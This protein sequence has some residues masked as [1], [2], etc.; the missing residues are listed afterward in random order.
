MITEDGGLTLNFEDDIIDAATITHQGEI[1]GRGPP[2]MNLVTEITIPV[3]AVFVGFEVISKV[4]TTL[5]AAD[6]ADQR[7]PRDRPAGRPD[8]G[9]LPDDF[10]GQ[11]IGFIAIVFGTINIVGGFMVTDRMLEM[12]GPKKKKPEPRLNRQLPI[13]RRTRRRP[14]RESASRCAGAGFVAGRD[15]HRQLLAVHH[16]DQAGHPP[17]TARRG[18]MIAAVGMAIAVI[19]TLCLKGIGNWGII[20]AGI[21][22]A[23]SS[24]RSPRSGSR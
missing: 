8:R 19:T 22:S 16:R 1:R 24:A 23:R 12:F 2:L 5:H 17:T 6:V 3:L 18:N 11:L 13:L 9:R 21:W 7:D 4:P 10:L 20:I 15:S 14:A